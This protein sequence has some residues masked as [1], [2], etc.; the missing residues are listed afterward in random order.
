MLFPSFCPS[1]VPRFVLSSLPP[2]F[3]QPPLSIPLSLIFLL[4][5]SIL[6]LPCIVFL[7]LF[8][9]SFTLL[10]PV[11]SCLLS[12]ASLF[13]PCVPVCRSVS[14]FAFPLYLPVPF[15]FLS[16]FLFCPCV[17]NVSFSLSLSFY[18]LVS[19]YSSISLLFLRVRPYYVVNMFLYLLIS[20]PFCPGV[21]ILQSSVGLLSCLCGLSS[22]L[23]MLLSLSSHQ[24]RS[25]SF[26]V[27]LF[28]RPSVPSSCPFLLSSAC[29]LR[30][31]LSLPSPRL[32][33][34]PWEC[35]QPLLVSCGAS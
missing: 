11:H 3:P 5:L 23:S 32:P 35:P 12:P 22:F 20:L 33:K 8:Y 24:F 10:A 27:L 30:L 28:L 31:L 34:W 26:R 13:C 7:S 6:V 21:S 25:P 19:V 17:T 14:L 4:F 16:R 29:Y 2:R 18:L 9:R 1:F 15:C